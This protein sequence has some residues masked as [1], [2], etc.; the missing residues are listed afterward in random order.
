MRE[1]DPDVITG[2][3]AIDF[4]LRVLDGMARAWK[5]PMNLGR[6]P[7]RLVLRESRFPWASLEA[8]VPGRVII[9]G[10]HLLRTSFVTMDSYSLDFV[11]REV[12]GEGKLITGGDR[13]GEIVR[14]FLHEREKFVAYN[15]KDARLVLDILDELGLMELS[16]QRSLLTGLPLDR[17][18]G[19]IAALDF[20][21][22]SELRQRDIIAPSVEGDE[23]GAAANLGGHVL[24]PET[25]LFD[26][27]LVFDFKSLY[28]S[29]IRTF[30]V[31]P[32]GYLP[33]PHEG[34]DPILAPTGAAF[35]R[36]QGILPGL[37]A[38]LF[39]RREKAKAEGNKIASHAIK[40]L[41][42]SF[43]G[44]LGT[45]ACRF[46]R[47]ELAGAITS[48]GRTLLLW[49]K[50]CFEGYGYRVIYGDTDSLFVLSGE[51]DPAAAMDLGRRL[52]VRL[53]RDLASHLEETWRV[54]SRLELELERLYL[55]L[56]MVPMRR[57]GGG[58]RKRYAGLVEKDGETEVVFTGMEVVRRDWTGAGQA[59]AAGAL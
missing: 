48:F 23:S 40:I 12:L 59:G 46:Y 6:G 20:L 56:L 25:G 47:P 15:L 10:I 9:D 17:V 29:V 32:L 18:S 52:V 33:D 36:Q 35:R 49:S 53:N 3:N 39:P 11:S 41:M 38:D 2:W 34:D 26:N 1:I 5:V 24:E 44:V 13:A 42:N 4:D 37:V 50:A 19:S 43:Y 58:A 22:L 54:E 45:T 57:G 30:Q 31:D 51:D 27:V 21:Y 16:V 14:T 7:G 8:V 55:R 28:P